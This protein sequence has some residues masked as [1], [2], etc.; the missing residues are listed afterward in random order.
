MQRRRRK[1]LVDFSDLEHFALEIL[2]EDKDGEKLP[3][4]AALEIIQ[5]FEEIMIDEYQDSNFVQ[6]TILTSISRDH[7]GQPN[8]F[9]VGD[10]KQSIYKFRLAMPEI[11]IEKYNDYSI[12]DEVDGEANKFQ[13]IDLDKNFRSRKIVLDSVNAVFSQIMRKSV[14]GIDYDEAASLKYGELYEELLDDPEDADEGIS[15]IQS[16]YW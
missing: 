9:M 8:R 14:G 2:V 6:E 10:V 5:Q 15:V 4:K 1:N 3:S 12:Q 16:F 7:L 13:R 11:F